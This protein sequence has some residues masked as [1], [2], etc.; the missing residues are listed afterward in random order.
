MVMETARPAG[1]F[2]QRLLARERLVGTFLKTPGV[3]A[4][5]ILGGLGYDF[6]VIDTEHAPFNPETVDVM[7]LAARAAGLAGVVRVGDVAQALAVLDMGAEGVLIPHVDS[8]EKARRAVAACRYRGGARGFTN[9][10]RAGGYGALGIAAHVAAADQ[11]VAVIAMIEDPAAMA[12]I[13]EILAVDG[14][15]AVFIGRGDLTVAY[16]E[17]AMSAKPVVEA[18]ARVLA[19]A[20]R[21]G[22][23]A[24]LMTAGA[25]EAAGHL[26]AGASAFIHG[27]DQGFMR[28]AAAAVLAGYAA[29]PGAVVPGEAS[30]V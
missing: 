14:L 13:D 22:K 21:A 19:A 1:G 2:R 17:T 20:A 23:P 3:H 12:V 8:A 4:T 15:D 25:D 29:L 28:Q 30:H 24:C 27:S 5:E 7:L 11:R 9:S 6:V 26:R 10:S 16:G 18:T